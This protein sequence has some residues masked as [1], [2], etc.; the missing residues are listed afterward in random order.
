MMNVCPKC[1]S[2][3][4]GCD[5]G[6]DVGNG[7]VT[8]FDHYAAAALTGLLSYGAYRDDMPGLVR[9]RALG[10]AR[11]MVIDRDKYMP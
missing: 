1:N 4:C 10:Y 5:A 8:L 9:S 11:Q 7:E 6:E 3:H 2:R